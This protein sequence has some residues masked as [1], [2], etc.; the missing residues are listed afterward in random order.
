MEE[1][2]ST[3]KSNSF[4]DRRF[5]E[6]DSFM[7]L[8]DKM[9]LRMKKDRIRKAKT[10]SLFN[11]DDEREEDVLTHRGTVLGESNVREMDDE[12]ERDSEGGGR[13]DRD[14]VDSLHFGG[15]LIPKHS[16]E[17]D[18]E[19]VRRF[20]HLDALQEV[21]LKS[22]LHKLEMKKEKGEQD[23]ERER[24][25]KE[26][27]SLIDTAQVHFRPTKRDFRE[28]LSSNNDSGQDSHDE[29]DKLFH[30]MVFE[31]RVRP[32]DRTKTPEELAVDARKRLEE[33]ET[34]RLERM[35]APGLYLGG[36][37]DEA[38]IQRALS[39][40]R[41]L[42]Q[43]DDDLEDHKNERE[44]ICR[45]Q[46]SVVGSSE[47]PV[48]VPLLDHEQVENEEW[49]ESDPQVN[50]E[51]EGEERSMNDEHASSGSEEHDPGDSDD[52]ST[53]SSSDEEERSDAQVYNRWGRLKKAPK[54]DDGVNV[55][56]PHNIECPNSLEH[57]DELVAQYVESTADMIALIDR[58]IVWNSVHL[59][60]PDGQ[61]NR[62]L[63]HNF[64]DM[65]L[66]HFIRVGDSLSVTESGSNHAHI[67]VEVT[68]TPVVLVWFSK[69]Y[70]S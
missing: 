16:T 69:V 39:G 65:L 13:L 61:R 62:T 20:S 50:D 22:K 14:I 68:L 42:Q 56:M 60:A 3:K 12:W 53:M 67:V 2:K 23:D 4:V 6:S 18:L 25:D 54:P 55:N 5:G 28:S 32:S 31:G 47:R 43:T 7:S 27:R 35:K 51:D 46:I 19:P 24:L 1:Y 63:M 38:E 49:N 21:V 58:I 8:E 41:K 11:L 33:L 64:L 57:F 34:A 10:S 70:L 45:H 30:E 36:D 17:I 59:P 40:R 26:F 37:D 52:N 66:K 29:Y 48:S 44:S 15:G 9:Y